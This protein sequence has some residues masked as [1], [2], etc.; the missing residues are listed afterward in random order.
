[1]VV[2][3]SGSDEEVQ[4]MLMRMRDEGLVKFDI[5]SGLWSRA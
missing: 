5:N 4:T 1:M 2:N 3:P